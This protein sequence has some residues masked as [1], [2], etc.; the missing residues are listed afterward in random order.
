L[1]GMHVIMKKFEPLLALKLIEQHRVG[2]TL[3]IPTMI[4]SINHL[5]VIPYNTDSLRVIIFGGA[6]APIELIHKAET[7]FKNAHFLQ[8]FGMT[9]LAPAITY[10][11]YEFINRNGKEAALAK[12]RSTSCGIP[13]P[14]VQVQIVDEKFNICD[15]NVIGEI[16]CKGPNLMLGYFKNEKETQKSIIKGWFLTGDVGY[17]DE[18]GFVYIVDRKKDM[19]ISG[20]ENIYSVEVEAC[21]YSHPAIQEACVFGVPHDHWG[22][23]PIAYVVLKSGHSVPEHKLISYCREKIAHYKIPHQIKFVEELPK[24]GT[25]KILK[26]KLREKY[27]SHKSS[28]L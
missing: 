4:N 28:K 5:Q 20:G 22:E 27:W 15:R 1:G 23:V 16:A 7:I 2:S 11:P 10:M 14:G 25:N 19:I 17:I 3:W 26:A 13:V 6:P 12:K 24:G 8:I 21:I 9:E 18:F